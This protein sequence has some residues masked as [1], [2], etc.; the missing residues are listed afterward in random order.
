M[1]HKVKLIWGEHEVEVTPSNNIKTPLETVVVKKLAHLKEFQNLIDWAEIEF[2]QIFQVN[3]VTIQASFDPDLEQVILLGVEG[4][5]DE[6]NNYLDSI[7]DNQDDYE[8]TSEPPVVF[9]QAHRVK[10]TKGVF[11][12][13]IY[14]TL[15]ATGCTVLIIGW[16][17]PNLRELCD[18]FITD[19]YNE[20]SWKFG[21]SETQRGV[22]SY[23]GDMSFDELVISL[24]DSGYMLVD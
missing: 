7:M 23:Y 5:E 21:I 20:L 16:K 4:G 2:E 11:P 19:I 9:L 3:D 10:D 1:N 8:D 17:D 24:S 22:L 18:F 14:N 6:N 15:I 12:D 13:E